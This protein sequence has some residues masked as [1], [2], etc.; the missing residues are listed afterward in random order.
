MRRGLRQRRQPLCRAGAMWCGGVCARARC[1]PPGR[2][3]APPLA[4]ARAP[5]YRRAT[6]HAAAAAAAGPEAGSGARLT[7]AHLPKLLADF[8]QKV[9]VSFRRQAAQFH[10]AATRLATSPGGRPDQAADK[11]L[12]VGGCLRGGRRK[13]APF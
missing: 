12:R 1:K 2:H 9:C 4:V 3:V 10:D 13:A 6:S 7:A 11:R 8:P 5:A